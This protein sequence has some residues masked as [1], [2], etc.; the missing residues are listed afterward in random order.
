MQQNTET[1]ISHHI[2]NEENKETNLKNIWKEK[3]KEQ[4]QA[5][6]K[7]TMQTDSHF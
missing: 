2:F 4:S 1:K 5:K 3:E 6:E 7:H